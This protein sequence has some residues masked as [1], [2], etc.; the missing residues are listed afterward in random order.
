MIGQAETR[1][2][3]AFLAYPLNFRNWRLAGPGFA[4]LT[5][6]SAISNAAAYQ[7][8]SSLPSG[9][10]ELDPSA[11]PGLL[12]S[13]GRTEC[14][15]LLVSFLLLALVR[16]PTERIALQSL[17]TGFLTADAV[18]DLVLFETGSWLLATEFAYVAAASIPTIAVL[19]LVGERVK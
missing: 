12:S 2:I 8:S 5:L 19:A 11:H 13:L 7:V 10:V 16:N 1:R 9:Y 6:V 3:L 14:T 17:V 18:N 4:A 15:I